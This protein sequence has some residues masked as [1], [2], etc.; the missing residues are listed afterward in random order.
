MSWSLVDNSHN[1]AIVHSRPGKGGLYGVRPYNFTWTLD[2][3]TFYTFTINH[4]CGDGFSS[5][6]Y[7]EVKMEKGQVIDTLGSDRWFFR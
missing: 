7:S 4:S 3:R 1:G 5:S 6:A 2:Q